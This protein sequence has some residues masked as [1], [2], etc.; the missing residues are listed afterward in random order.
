MLL[1]TNWY[2]MEEG[3]RQVVME[4]GR[5]KKKKRLFIPEQEKTDRFVVVVAGF[6]FDNM[7]GAANVFTIIIFTLSFSVC[8]ALL[9]IY[10]FLAVS[11][12]LLKLFKG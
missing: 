2:G 6:S 10:I 7:V 1:P 5:V 4:D 11:I 9:V 12:R 8:H 3:L